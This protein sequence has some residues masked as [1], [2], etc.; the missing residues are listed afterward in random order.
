L[1]LRDGIKPMIEEWQRLPAWH[2]DVGGVVNLIR[3]LAQSGDTRAVLALGKD[4]LNRKERVQWRAIEAL[5]SHKHEYKASSPLDFAYARDEVLVQELA[6]TDRLWGSMGTW[7]KLVGNPRLCD[8]A[9]YYLA[10][11]WKPGIEFDITSPLLTRDRYRIDL[12]NTWRQRHDLSL[13]PVPPAQRVQRFPDF[14]VKP[15][16]EML[17]ALRSDQQ[18]TQALEE[19][20]HFGLAA[21]PAVREA[22][23]G[24]NQEH[25]AYAPL[26]SVALRVATTVR[27][28]EFSYNSAKPS[29]QTQLMVD[30]LK[31]KPLDLDELTKFAMAFTRALPE[32][33]AGF[34]VE[35]EREGDNSG[36]TLRFTLEKGYRLRQRYDTGESV[37]VNGREV[38]SIGSAI[39]YRPGM[40]AGH[41]R[42]FRNGLAKAF[43]TGL[44]TEVHGR[45]YLVLRDEQP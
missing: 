27:E 41:W 15:K 34:A 42:E 5:G 12:I 19:I 29:I 43:G 45:A 25:P 3:F 13:L 35:V 16:I 4:L 33:V 17:L 39:S 36:V 32:G 6:N 44:Q 30:R 37:G 28:I 20:E 7:G 9:A 24:M 40:T 14:V 8:L 26:K 2:N 10:E 22:L 38:F 31:G 21:L 11:L 18:S 23:A 1:G